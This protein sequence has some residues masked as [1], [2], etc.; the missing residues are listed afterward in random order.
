MDEFSP[1][2]SVGDDELTGG[3]G[4][5]EAARAGAAGIEVKDAA[6]RLLPGDMAM[7]RDHDLDSGCLWFQIEL[8][9][10]VQHEDG[11]AGDLDEFGFGQFAGPRRLVDIAA[12]GGNGR[13]GRELIEDFGSANV[14]GVNDALRSAQRLQCLRPKQAVS[15]R[16]D[17][18]EGGSF[19][20]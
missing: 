18:N 5:F 10:I 13:D 1:H 8:R 16:D 9:E 14:S 7:A 15:V 17:A 4:Q 6:A 11:N 19:Q 12:D 3:Y 2:G 20:F